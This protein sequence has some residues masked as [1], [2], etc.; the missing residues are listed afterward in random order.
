MPK[1]IHTQDSSQQRASRLLLAMGVIVLLGALAYFGLTLAVNRRTPAN[2]DTHFDAENGISVDY[3]SAIWPVCQMTEDAA[4]GHA[5]QLASGGDSANA[6]YQ[7][8]LFQR[9][10]KATY[11]DFIGQSEA[12]LKAAYGVISPRKVKLQ[13]EGA[14]VTAVRCDIQAYHAG[15]L[16]TAGLHQRY[17]QSGGKREPDMSDP[18]AM[19]RLCGLMRKAV[20]DYEMISPGDKIMVGVSGGKDSVA[21]T[22]GLALLRRYLGFDYEVVAVTLDPQFD[23]QAVD[24]SPLAALFA[25]YEVPYEVRRTEI[26]P[27]V[28]EYRQEKNPCS[29]CA[30]LRRGALHTAAQELGC[31]KVALGHHLDDA[32]ETFY[33]N[34]WREGR[35][36]CFSPVTQL[37]RRG[38]TLIRP[39]LLATEHEVRCAVK[40]EDFPIVKSRC[41]ADGVTVREQT[42]DFVRERCRTDHAFRQKTLHA[43]QESGID[44]WRPVH[45]GRTSN[46]S[47]KEGMHH[48]DAEL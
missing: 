46:P 20:Q 3:E 23:H 8:V 28:F 2:P 32:V 43:L 35:I 21:L 38:L 24:Y 17:R 1:D 42:K 10:D 26:G 30:R 4:L 15:F 12:D 44:G 37:D 48:A 22:I 34:L 7:V 25:R 33:M 40:E 14:T 6:N 41:P 36:G 39:M 19:Q 9:G 29:L 27:I 13:V 18:H 31:N 11:E 47:P 16:P 45:T 5:L